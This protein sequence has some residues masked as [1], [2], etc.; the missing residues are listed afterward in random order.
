VTDL[1]NFIFGEGDRMKKLTQTL[2][3]G[4]L[5]LVLGGIASGQT[6]SEKEMDEEYQ[7]I[8]DSGTEQAHLIKNYD[9]IKRLIIDPLLPLA[10]EG[11]MKSQHYLGSL[12]CNPMASKCSLSIEWWK[13]ASDQGN[14]ESSFELS[15]AYHKG[16]GVPKDGKEAL[17][18]LKIGA[19]QGHPE[20]LDSL[21]QFYEFGDEHPVF[22]KM[23]CSDQFVCQKDLKKAKEY[24][25]LANRGKTEGELEKRIKRDILRIDKKIEEQSLLENAKSS[26]IPDQQKEFISIVTTHADKYKN[27]KND[28]KKSITRKKRVKE[29]NS[30]FGGENKKWG[31]YVK[32]TDMEKAQYNL[33]CLSDKCAYAENQQLCERMFCKGK[34]ATQ[35]FILHKWVAKESKFWIGTL[36]NI[37]TDKDGDATVYIDLGNNIKIRNTTG[38]SPDSSMY[39]Q[40]G[41]LEEGKKVIFNGYFKLHDETLTSGYFLKTIALT[42][43]GA[44]IDPEFDFSFQKFHLN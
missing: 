19:D 7:R 34:K 2:I 4:V 12:Y 44:L 31:R 30:L 10:E 23:V 18:W 42:E 32:K 25:L 37:T 35:T 40:L 36:S 21:G 33:Q 26:G 41:E 43:R 28:I 17:K 38:I 5:F 1:S 29:L 39:E 6:L 15:H 14:G 16:I 3:A 8:F 22:A 27:A 13:K 11:H 20:S 24:Y 9:D